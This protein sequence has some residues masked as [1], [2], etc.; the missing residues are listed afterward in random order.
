MRR[1][2]VLPVVAACVAVLILPGSGSG[3]STSPVSVIAASFKTEERATHYVMDVS[4]LKAPVH[5]EWPL[6][7]QCIDPGCPADPP[8]TDDAPLPNIDPGC[9][10]NGVG[11]S[12]P[13]VQTIAPG[14]LAEFVWHHPSA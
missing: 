13:F 1:I 2:L 4:G 6:T 7:L 3:D 12:A 11:T 10:N 9:D 8:G 14:E 5:A